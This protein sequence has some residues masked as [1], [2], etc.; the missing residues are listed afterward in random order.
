MWTAKYIDNETLSQFKENGEENLFKNIQQDKLKKFE[1]FINEINYIV[2]I[3][4]GTFTIDGRDLFFAGF[5]EKESYQ[6]IYFRRVRRDLNES[7]Q[8]LST[9]VTHHIGWKCTLNGKE[10]QRVL[11]VNDVTKAVSFEVK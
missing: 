9:Q 11:R 6:L 7:M 4:D 2:N 10:H 8:T 1:I 5:S 3:A